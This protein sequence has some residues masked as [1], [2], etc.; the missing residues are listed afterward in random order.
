MKIFVPS[1]NRS[2]KTYTR[3][4]L[5]KLSFKHQVVVHNQE[6]ADKYK[7]NMQNVLIAD[8]PIGVSHIRQWIKDN[9]VEDDEWFMMFDDNIKE[10]NAFP[11]PYYKEDILD[12]KNNKQWRRPLEDHI[13]NKIEFENIIAE[14]INK[15]NN[16]GAR[17]A[18]FAVVHN[19][20]FRAKKWRTAGYGISKIALVR[21]DNINY[22]PKV[23]AMDDYAF[24]AEQLLHH[25]KI[26]INN[27]MFPMA[28][29]YEGGGIGTYEERLEKKIADCK[30]LMNKYPGLFRYKTKKNCHPEAELQIRF[31]SEKQVNKW[32]E[33]FGR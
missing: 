5:N 8:C 30:Y 26:L 21:K 23:I 12:V 29:H 10:I 33:N 25:G 28:G 17:Y 9:C 3:N 31:T 4:L 32:R 15:A 1:H 20:Y 18:T 24:T 14:T 13:A 22:D 7:Q 6:Q 11:E 2:D 27:F 16:I 19:Y